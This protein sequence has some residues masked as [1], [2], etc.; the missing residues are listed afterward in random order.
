M[1]SKKKLIVEYIRSNIILFIVCLWFG[2]IFPIGA[3][4]GIIEYFPFPFKGDIMTDIPNCSVCLFLIFL[5][6]FLVNIFGG[7]FKRLFFIL[8]SN[9]TAEKMVVI[10][11]YSTTDVHEVLDTTSHREVKLVNLY[12]DTDKY[13]AVSVNSER[14]FNLC[15]YGYSIYVINIG[16]KKNNQYLWRFAIPCEL[17]ESN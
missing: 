13:H 6:Y 16:K 10:A 2:L 17:V 15:K 1:I 9:Y 14:H 5:I 3:I 11:K 7:I 4:Y 8:L 12:I